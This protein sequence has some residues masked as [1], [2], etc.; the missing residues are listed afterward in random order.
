M[1]S[2]QKFNVSDAFDAKQNEL[3]QVLVGGR[4]V[5]NH[6]VAVG[7]GTELRWKEMLQRFLPHRYSVCKGFVV[8]SNGDS[9]LQIDIIIYDRTFSPLFWELGDHFYIPAESVYAVFE[10][11]QEHNA[12]Y[13]NS[14][15]EKA[16]SVRDLKRT[17]AAFGWIGGKAI[18]EPFSILAGLL[19]VDST[20]SPSFGDSFYSALSDVPAN[21]HLDLGC[22][23][24]EGSWNLED[25]SDVRS[26]LIS[27]KET[28]LMSFCMNL[29][30][31]L[32]KMGTVG[33]IDYKAYEQTGGLIENNG[34]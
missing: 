4:R 27:T 1:N 8:D 22:A 3:L 17:E 23:L 5:G 28:S 25:Q 26:A 16:T 13:M 32:Q 24:S 14:A 6:P 30:Y 19:T 31:R 20:W 10:V 15:S 18:K 21:G 12:D 29:L 7:D 11:K 9:S 34:K 2:K 33:G